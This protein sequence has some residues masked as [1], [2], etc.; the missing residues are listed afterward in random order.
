MS[1][2]RYT[3]N[4]ALATLLQQNSQRGAAKKLG[5]NS[6]T[7]ERWLSGEYAPSKASQEKIRHAAGNVRRQLVAKAKRENYEPIRATV[8]VYGYRRKLRQ[9]GREGKP[10]GQMIYSDWTNYRVDRLSL[11]QALAVLSDI[12]RMGTLVQFIFYDLL[13]INSDGSRYALPINAPVINDV[14]ERSGST[15]FDLAGYSQ[16]DLYILLRKFWHGEYRPGRSNLVYI[17]SLLPLLPLQP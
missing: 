15:H 10:T 13:G 4:E 3:I 2:Q 8:P 9:H 7:L 1:G 11:E 6:R 14:V 16:R 12:Q 5:V 17:A